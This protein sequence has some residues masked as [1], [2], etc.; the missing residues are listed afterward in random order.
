M[1]ETSDLIFPNLKYSSFLL[2]FIVISPMCN[3]TC[4]SWLLPFSFF[5]YTRNCQQAEFIHSWLT[6]TMP[7]TLTIKCSLVSIGDPP[8]HNPVISWAA[9]TSFREANLAAWGPTCCGLA[10][11][12]GCH[13]QQFNWGGCPLTEF[14]AGDLWLGRVKVKCLLLSVRHVSARF[15]LWKW[16][17][18]RKVTSVAR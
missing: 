9:V 11:R 8:G 13:V 17:E 3:V 1:H 15:N 2:Y 14:L 6:L 12:H 4:L 18:M 10:R 7:F 16:G 5:S